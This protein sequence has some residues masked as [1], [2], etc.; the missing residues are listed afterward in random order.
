MVEQSGSY[1]EENFRNN[2]EKFDKILREIKDKFWRLLQE[3]KENVIG[4]FEK[5]QSHKY[6]GHDFFLEYTP[7]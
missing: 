2:S 7:Y 6:L 1:S 3:F 5:V 4:N